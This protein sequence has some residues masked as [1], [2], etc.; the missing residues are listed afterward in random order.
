MT[1]TPTVNYKRYLALDIHK[2]YLVV[3]GVDI[4]QKIILL[5]RRVDYD[6]WAGWMKANLKSS[7]AIVLEATT[8]AWQIYDQVFPYVGQA[9]VAHSGLVKL[10]ASARV[11]TDKRDVLKLARLLA[12]G[13]VPE[14][15][16]PPQEVRDLRALLAH[17]MHMIKRRTM[18]RNRLQSVIHR[19]NLIPPVGDLYESANQDWWEKVPVS[20]VEQLRI[21]QDL[22]T[23][24]HLEPQIIECDAEL[25]R[26]SAQKPW[27]DQIIYL[28]QL[29]GIGLLIGMTILA[30]IGDIR[31]FPNS[32]QLVGYAGL[33]AGVHFSGETHHT[34]RITKQGRKDLRWALVEAAW[35]AVRWNPY[36]K[37]HFERI[38]KRRGK[39][40]AIVAVARKLLTVI[41]HVLTKKV[42]DHQADAEKVAY[43]LFRWTWK[44]DPSQ[45][46]GL[47]TRQFVRYQLLNLNIGHDLQTIHLGGKKR[48]LPS[49]D[50]LRDLFPHL[51]ASN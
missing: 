5:P 25:E 7:D 16:V 14:V 41:W 37:A 51:M 36:W 35:V 10:I 26:R 40:K 47:Q 29:P 23:L 48:S 46:Q 33:G 49:P 22:A 15:W 13:L 8:N 38:A 6:R 3:G 39:N 21:R 44:L 11:K 50:E 31:R 19:Y 27:R 34:G 30:A 20:T 9:V 45:R 4:H 18:L 28:L 32:K 43:K 42:A 17:R 2:H 1:D 12:A 24:N